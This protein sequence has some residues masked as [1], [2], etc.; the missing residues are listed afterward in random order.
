MHS[1]QVPLRQ[2]LNRAVRYPA[3][4]VVVAS[5]ALLVGGWIWC[6]LTELDRMRGA[7]VAA[8]DR[9]DVRGLY[10]LTEPRER[11]E[12]H[13]TQ[14]AMRTMLEETLWNRGVMKP[15]GV[16]VLI[17]Q[18]DRGRVDYLITWADHAGKPIRYPIKFLQEDSGDRLCSVLSFHRRENDG[19]RLNFT[20]LIWANCTV[21]LGFPGRQWY[22]DL[23]R[24]TGVAGRMREDGKML[25]FQSASS[26]S[27]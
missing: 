10:A 21:Q 7:A 4:W 17:A 15:D 12:L 25:T 20:Q 3:F 27:S 8:L 6:V 11:E 1:A 14:G 26:G 24:R 19:W 9:H 5:L 2:A 13:L 16:R 18:K 23:C 22:Q